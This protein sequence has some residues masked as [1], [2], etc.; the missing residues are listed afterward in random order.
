MVGLGGWGAMLSAEHPAAPP[1]VSPLRCA[2]VE[3]WD[4]GC[5][6][7]AAGGREILKMIQDDSGFA[8]IKKGSHRK[9]RPFS[10]LLEAKAI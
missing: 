9:M 1:K 4:P 10:K 8:D 7:G 6:E 3:K 5:S 2:S